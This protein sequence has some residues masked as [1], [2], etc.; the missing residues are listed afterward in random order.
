M[1]Y[2]DEPI[3]PYRGQMYCHMAT[4]GD[5]E[6]LHEMADKIGLSRRWFQNHPTHPHYDLAPSKRILAIEQGAVETTTL[7]MSKHCFWYKPGTYFT[8]TIENTQKE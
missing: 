4:D 5:L 1:I 6:E 7:E 2:V 3:F 8:V